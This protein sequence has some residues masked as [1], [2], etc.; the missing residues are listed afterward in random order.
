MRRPTHRPKFSH[1]LV[2]GMWWVWIILTALLF[3]LLGL[4]STRSNFESGIPKIIHQTAPAD[5]SKWPPTWKL[6]QKTWKEKFP[7]WE[8]KFWNDEDLENLIKEDYSWFYPT[9]KGYDQQIKRVDAAR[10]FMLHK[11]GG[12]YADMD[13]ECINNFEHLLPGDK[14]SIAESPYKNDGREDT[15]THQNALMISPKGH[16]FWERVFEVLEEKKNDNVV[17]YATGPYVIIKSIKGLEHYVNT[18]AHD[19][20]A[21]SHTEVF[22][23]AQFEN[24]NQL[25]LIENKNVFA[26]HLGTG[27]WV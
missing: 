16:P 10:C 4:L 21:P 6:C 1:V 2:V 7:S 18:L 27:V 19:L 14:V 12:M 26:R 11:Y 22:K 23:R 24:Y 20:F 17:V 13:Y 8:Y 25:P 9:Y 5:E 3:V 15:E